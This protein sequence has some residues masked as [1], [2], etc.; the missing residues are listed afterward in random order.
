MQPHRTVV[1]D[2]S[3]VYGEKSRWVQDFDLYPDAVVSPWAGYTAPLTDEAID[4][5]LECDVLY[6]AETYYDPRIPPLAKKR[7]IPTFKHVNCEL[8]SDEGETHPVYPSEWRL[9]HVPEGPTLP[10]PIPDDR[11]RPPAGEGP[12]LHVAG[13]QAAHDRNGTKLVASAIRR[14]TSQWRVTAQYGRAV[15]PKG[16]VVMVDEV[17]DRW[18]LYEGC[19]VL[20]LP[21]RYGGLCLPALEAAAS[22]LALVMP[23]IPPND[24]WPIVPLTPTRVFPLRRQNLTVTYTAPQQIASI[25][26]SLTGDTLEAAQEAAHQWA[27]SLAWSKMRPAYL[28]MFDD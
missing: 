3:P 16:N 8:Y 14:S 17:D 27:L 26:D 19:S 11:I 4:V 23:N 2:M 10:V 21:R 24:G 15:V 13:W 5:L 28:S 1:V 22:G 20:V 7:G 6:S 25:V 9:P 18:S 12:V